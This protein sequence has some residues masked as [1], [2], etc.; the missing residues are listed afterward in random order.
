MLGIRTIIITGA[1]FAYAVT[2][3][4]AQTA[5]GSSGKPLPLLPVVQKKGVPK[6]HAAHRHRSHTRHRV[7]A[8]P[9]A[10][11]HA[12]PHLAR[13]SVRRHRTA[14]AAQPPQPATSAPAAWPAPDGAT[15]AALQS[16]APAS[17]PPVP[18]TTEPVVET[19]PNEI[20]T[21]SPAVPTARPHEASAIAP[22]AAEHPDVVKSATPVP[23]VQAK[24]AVRAM[25]ATAVR[26][27]PSPVGSASWIA[28]V[29]AALGGALAAGIVAWFLIK[30]APQGL[31]EHD[32]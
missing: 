22:A 32:Y 9:F 27:N 5:P 8:K 16:F 24:P 7:A 23:A 25:V 30:P 13:H 18:V 31:A 20:V 1:V 4:F 14:L 29:L 11:A 15:P 19:N 28:Q 2:G 12:A 17:S 3:A 10:P 21:G 6:T 26:A